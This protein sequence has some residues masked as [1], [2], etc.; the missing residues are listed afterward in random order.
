MRK[1]NVVYLNSLITSGYTKKVDITFIPRRIWSPEATTA[2]LIRKRELRRERFT[3]E[4][5]FEDFMMPFQK[6][7]TEKA[8]ALE[9]AFKT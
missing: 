5:D 1:D 2:E 7:I 3:Y 4:V 8:K 9:A 6:N